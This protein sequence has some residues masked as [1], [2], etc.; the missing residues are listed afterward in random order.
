MFFNTFQHH[1]ASCW[2]FG[3]TISTT[4][5]AGTRFTVHLHDLPV[6][7]LHI[8]HQLQS[9]HLNRAESQRNR[10]GGKRNVLEATFFGVCSATGSIV[11]AMLLTNF[12]FLSDFALKENNTP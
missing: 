6:K 12:F 7:M 11:F 9:M 10:Y 3:N 5:Q 1:N 8:P 4:M 2:A